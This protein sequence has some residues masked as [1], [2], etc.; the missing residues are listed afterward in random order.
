MTVNGKVRQSG[1]LHDM[2]YP[3]PHLISLISQYCTLR[4]GDLIYTGTPSGVGPSRRA[5]ISPS[6]LRG[7]RWTITK[8]PLKPA[9][10][11]GYY[12]SEMALMTIPGVSIC[13]STTPTPPG[14]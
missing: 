13:G 9:N 11:Q 3:I 1:H 10:F 8:L 14:L 7:G 5:M 2:I 12:A 6:L 4:A